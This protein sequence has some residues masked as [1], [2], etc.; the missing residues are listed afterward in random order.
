MN[1]SSIVPNRLPP[2]AAARASRAA[3]HVEPAPGPASRNARPPPL[4]SPPRRNGE[5]AKHSRDAGMP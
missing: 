3:G 4:P 5:A 1:E 2:I